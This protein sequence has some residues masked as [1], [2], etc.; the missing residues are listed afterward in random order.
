MVSGL[1]RGV[2][3]L[4]HCAAAQTYGFYGFFQVQG[5]VKHI[6]AVVLGTCN[7]EAESEKQKR[8]VQAY[9]CTES[10]WRLRIQKEQ[11]KNSVL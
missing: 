2:R 6:V 8:R 4:W 5:A 7:S 3:R 1:P 10:P 11:L 9:P